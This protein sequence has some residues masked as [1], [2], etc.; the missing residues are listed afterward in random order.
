MGGVRRTK[1][2]SS[3]NKG[4]YPDMADFK[5]LLIEKGE[6]GLAASFKQV[7]DSILMAGDVD[8]RVTHS[9]VNFKDGLAFSGRIPVKPLPLRPGQ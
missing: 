5:A 7:D 2:K 8:V 4:T 1:K 6:K 3:Q 9:T